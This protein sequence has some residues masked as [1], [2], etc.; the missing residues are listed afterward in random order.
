MS[1][2]SEATSDQTREITADELGQIAEGTPQNKNP[3]YGEPGSVA[4]RMGEESR[5][6]KTHATRWH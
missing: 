4:D 3:D 6:A 5:G 2:T 1:K